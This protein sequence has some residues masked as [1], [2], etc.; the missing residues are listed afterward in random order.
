M[1][2]NFPKSF[3][4]NSYNV[5]SAEECALIFI[6]N[7]DELNSLIHESCLVLSKGEDTGSSSRNIYLDCCSH[8]SID[9]GSANW[10]N[11]F[12][13]QYGDFSEN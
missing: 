6:Y 2:R 11:L 10:Y 4:E 9:G 1:N 13:Y 8:P 7:K 5:L 12:G 3:Q